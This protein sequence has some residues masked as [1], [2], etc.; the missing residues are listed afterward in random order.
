MTK[1]TI[2]VG[3]GHNALVCACYLARGGLDV[4]VLERRHIIGG[5]AVT[6]E[7]HPGFRNSVA[8]YTVSLLHQKVIDD[9][10]LHDH[11]LR[12]MERAVNNYLPLP[13]GDSFI[14]YPDLDQTR[15]EVA[16]F[17]GR[18]ADALVDYY[19]VLEAVVPVVREIML[20]TPPDFGGGIGDLIKLFKLSRQFRS[21]STDEKQFLLKL[22]SVAA[23]ELLDDWFESDPIKALLGFDAVVGNYSSPYSPGSAYI[24]LH[25]VVGQVNGKDGAWGHAVGG[26]GAITQAMSQEATSL[27]VEMITEADV[28]EILVQGNRPTGVRL[29]SGETLECDLVVAGIN[30]KLLFLDLIDPAHVDP[31]TRKHFQQYKCVSGTFRMNVALSAPPD[32]KTRVEGHCLEGGTIIA[33]SLAYMDAAFDDAKSLGWSSEP[34]V[35]MLVPS[36]VDDSLAPTD[37][38]VASLFCQHFDPSLGEA[39]DDHRE[40]V[41]DLIIDTVDEWAPGFKDSVQGRQIL[42]P[43]DLE[44]QFG[45]VGGDIFHGRMSLDQLFSARPRLGMGQ[46]RTDIDNLYMCGAGTHPGGGVTGLPGYNAAREILRSL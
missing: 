14:A 17:S 30:P 7:F 16:R 23:A 44:R 28:R 24:L 15:S 42:T 37:Q 36:L 32:F 22:F 2:I 33:P 29:A 31:A 6:E 26:M 35:E 11:G 38:H 4:T 9:L 27:G 46:Y 3:G 5:A 39:W 41:A 8:S 12:I 19:R 43:A 21:L 13:D 25:H 18:D 45:L 40:Q 34:I 10:H 20:M 1:K